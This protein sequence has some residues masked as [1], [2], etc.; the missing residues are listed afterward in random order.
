MVAVL[1]SSKRGSMFAV[2]GL[3]EEAGVL[4]PNHLLNS[5]EV[6]VLLIEEV[7]L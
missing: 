5:R 6:S 3:T 7:S 2:I 4:V 1:S